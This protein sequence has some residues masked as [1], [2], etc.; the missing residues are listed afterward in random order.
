MSDEIPPKMRK[1][2]LLAR[3]LREERDRNYTQPQSP[4]E[5]LFET[6]DFMGMIKANL[7]DGDSPEATIE[8]AAGLLH[9]TLAL[10]ELL[11]ADI[12]LAQLDACI[13]ANQESEVEL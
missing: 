13:E 7:D 10:A 5:A 8:N 2:L 4:E 3:V 9:A 6:D 12:S 1:F 11:M